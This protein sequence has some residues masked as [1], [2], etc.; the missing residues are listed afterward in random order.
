L[1][2]TCLCIEIAY[3]SMSYLRAFVTYFDS[4]CF[5]LIIE[6]IGAFSYVCLLSIT[7]YSADFSDS[8][9]SFKKHHFHTHFKRL[10]HIMCSNPYC[11]Y[12]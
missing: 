12:A 6:Y 7:E 4:S 5:I 2:V 3:R 1:A 8:N 10:R 9:F 11:I